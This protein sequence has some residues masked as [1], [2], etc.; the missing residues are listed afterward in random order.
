MFKI[1][2][3]REVNVVVCLVPLALL[4]CQ[5]RPLAGWG[6]K[7][8]LLVNSGIVVCKNLAVKPNLFVKGNLAEYL[9]RWVEQ[10]T[11][12]EPRD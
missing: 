8:M 5:A 1:L 2:L 10:G 12:W 3:T 7:S 6:L 9:K 4:P 11:D